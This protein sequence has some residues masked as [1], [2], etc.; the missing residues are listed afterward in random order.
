MKV[1]SRISV[2]LICM[3]SLFILNTNA[4]AESSEAL[5]DKVKAAISSTNAMERIGCRGVI[6][7]SR[8]KSSF[9]FLN[10]ISDQKTGIRVETETVLTSFDAVIRENTCYYDLNNHI[11]YYKD[12]VRNHYY[13]VPDGV[14]WYTESLHD[15]LSLDF[16][17]D[18]VPNDGDYYI[19]GEEDVTLPDGKTVKCNLIRNT[20]TAPKTYWF[21]SSLYKDI[22]STYKPLSDYTLDSYSQLSTSSDNATPNNSTS[23]DASSDSYFTISFEYAI[24]KD[25]G[26]IYR[27]VHTK[28]KIEDSYKSAH[29]FYYPSDEVNVPSE[30][31]LDATLGENATICKNNIYYVSYYNGDKTCFYAYDYKKKSAKTLS[32]ETKIKYLG[33]YYRVERIG[34][35]AF[36][37]MKKLTKVTIPKSV[38]T[39]D[40]KAFANCNKLKKVIVKNKTLKKKLKKNKSYRKKVGIRNKAKI[41]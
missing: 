20:H 21:D 14:D 17:L 13:Y 29:Y 11:R 19:Y 4:N 41:S 22:H 32:I 8:D 6:G 5:K 3:I 12:D 24:G 37:G 33:K 27:I 18:Y 34:E 23:A 9:I 28:G 25:D 10:E 36:N 7:G 26:L 31:S 2:V 38:V 39:I 35:N 1:L 30:Y 40:N 15:Y 16:Y